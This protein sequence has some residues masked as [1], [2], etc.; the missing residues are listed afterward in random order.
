[1]LSIA[2]LE[3]GDIEHFAVGAAMVHIDRFELKPAVNFLEYIF[4]GC[5]LHLTVAVDFTGS[6]GP[7][8]DPDSLH[9][10]DPTKNQYLKALTA[11]GG[12][13]QYYDREK[14][15]PA[16]GFG[17]KIKGHPST[18]HKFALNG[19]YFKPECNGLSG[20]IDAYHR[21]AQ[22][23]E[24]LGPTNFAEIIHDI[25]DRCKATEV[26]QHN[27]HYHLLVI[28]T[29]GIIDDIEQTIDEIVVG[30]DL[31]L[32]I[33]VVGIGEA[34]FTAMDVLDA[35]TKP[36]FSKTHDRQMSRDIV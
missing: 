25:N 3:H 35:D 19:D 24:F 4:G 20:V 28:L 8:S 36:L 33:V 11:V 23:T 26:S 9:S 7:P 30:S 15:I 13:L 17:A 32:S 22:M 34:D 6:N 5:Q 29:D 10:V 14:M 16:Y 2:N 18:Y 21:A 31:P 12:I 1:M 27:Q